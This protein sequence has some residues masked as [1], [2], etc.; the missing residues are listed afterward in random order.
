MNR[1]YL[2]DTQS[3]KSYLAK[4]TEQDPER[5][6]GSLDFLIQNIDKNLLD[7]LTG[8]KLMIEIDDTKKEVTLLGDT[9]PI[10]KRDILFDK[11]VNKE[12]IYNS[13]VRACDITKKM[14]WWEEMIREIKST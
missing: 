6:I 9:M 7:V 2:I 8:N 5:T 3:I 4:V 14:E 1:Y 13:I 10:K 12:T 11:E